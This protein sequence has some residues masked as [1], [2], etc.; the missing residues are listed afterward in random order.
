MARLLRLAA[1]LFPLTLIACTGEDADP[2][3]DAA[4]GCVEDTRRCEGAVLEICDDGDWSPVTFCEHG[5]ADEACLD[6]T[7]TPI[8]TGRR[9][10]DDGCG[11]SCGTCDDD[12]RCLDGRCVDEAGCGDAI[13]ADSEDCSTCPADCGA[14]C[15]DG[16]CAQDES[17]ANCPIDCTCPEGELCNVAA[18]EC[19]IGCEP[20][21]C[22]TVECGGDGCGGNCGACEGDQ[23]CSTGACIDPPAVCGDDACEPGESCLDCPADCGFCC[24]DLRC[25]SEHGEDCATCPADCGC[26]L[27]ERCNIAERACRPACVPDCDDRVC[28]D[29]GCGATCGECQDA[30]CDANGRCGPPPPRCGDDTCNLDEDCSTCPADCGTCCGD[31]TCRGG[32][33]CATCPAD[34]GCRD[35]ELCDV[36]ARVCIAAGCEPACQG[37]ICGPDGCGGTCGACDPGELCDPDRGRCFVPCAPQCAGRNCGDDGC[38]GDCGTC[39]GADICNDGRCAPPCQPLCDGRSCGDDGCGGTCGACLAAERCIDGLC[40]GGGFR[41]DCAAGQVC[42]AGRCRPAGDACGP[43]RPDGL[44]DNGADCVAGTC[45][46]AGLGCSPQRLN[47]ICPVGALCLEGECQSFDADALCTDDDPCTADAYDGTADACERLPVGGVC[48]DGNSCTR[49]D[50]CRAGTCGGEAI[51]GCLQPP[52]VDR[53]PTYTREPRIDLTGTRPAGSALVVNGEIAVPAGPIEAFRVAVDLVAGTNTFR[54]LSRS[55]GGDS[56]VATVQVIYDTE[57]PTTRITPGGRSYL[58]G[59]TVTVAASEPARV[60]YTTDG[61]A[62]DIFSDH[63]E[64]VHTF[65]IFDDTTLTVQAIDRAGN[66]QSAP[67]RERYVI[68]GD[69]NRWEVASPL[70]FARTD[71]AAATDGQRV[72]VVG[73]F[74]GLSTRG[75]VQVHDLATGTWSDRPALPQPRTGATAAVVNGALYVFGGADAEGRALD[76]ADKLSIAGGA[77]DA[78]TPMPSPRYGAQAVVIN[79]RV[80]VMG[81]RTQG[82]AVVTTHAIYDPIANTWS[83]GRA[84]PRPRHAFAAV[85]A[86][87]GL[88]HLLGGEDDAGRPIAAVDVYGPVADAWTIG[89][90]LPTPRSHLTATLDRNVGRVVGG[91]VGIVVAGGRIAGGTA[92]AIVEEFVL[93]DGIWVRRRPL[94]APRQGAAAVAF[95]LAATPDAETTAW[96]IGGTVTGPAGPAVS[97][98]TARYTRKQDHLRHLQPLP[99]G[100]FRHDA[101]SLDDRL[102]VVGGRTF[103]PT[104]RSYAYDPET[105]RSTLIAGLPTVQNGGAAVALRGRVWVV[106][107]ASAFGVAV[108]TVQAYDPIS[109]TWQ[110]MAPMASPRR[111]PVAVVI[112]DEIV[113][114][115]GDDGEA[116]QTVE[117]FNPATGA[118]RPAPSMP[119]AR[120]G[121]VGVAWQGR[122]YLA[123]GRDATGEV[124][125]ELWMFDPIEGSVDRAV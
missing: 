117:I 122:L 58:D 10:G 35:D 72:W 5:C 94:P 28:G 38:G 17:C 76:R 109:N 41:C 6:P 113:V 65:R 79:G 20:L 13:C 95:E 121:A 112:G 116:L 48:D 90:P 44:C 123:G 74:D 22:D 4:R 120:T 86:P 85:V 47:G 78:M 98:T 99:E 83:P 63:F 107:G 62:P 89:V 75:A 70:N 16:E 46:D 102:Y 25:L 7:C 87:D 36:P 8:C 27:D 103:Q 42:L 100:R 106:G 93:G 40:L 1:C 31:G 66:W 84:L 32:E 21:D 61:S 82:G 97:A 108:S 14:C 56:G 67:H 19:V 77:W 29:D 23:I 73:G 104:V 39:N 37:R 2:A 51:A 88:V 3:P 12:E 81:G 92:T 69:G 15:G 119:E 30:V 91:A 18:A 68:T 80:H 59:I 9:C 34:C 33:S 54:L 115:G 125:E 57:P 101:V 71:L 96:V 24:G 60:Y 11:G 64:S 49:N 43:A 53:L 110:V 105:G 111:D 50:L 55:A 26:G 118:W 114:A 52:R 124:R 45:L